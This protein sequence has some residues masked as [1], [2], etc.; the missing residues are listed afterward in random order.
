MTEV[1][2]RTEEIKLDQF[3]KLAAAVAGGGE[4]KVRVQSGEVTVN[5]AVETRR[6][7]RVRRGDVIGIGGR[8]YRVGPS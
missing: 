3:L 8:E 4:A 5:G 2:I 7:H 1:P 6:G